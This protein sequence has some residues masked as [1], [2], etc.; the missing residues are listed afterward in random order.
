MSSADVWCPIYKW[1]QKRGT[2]Y[3]TIFVPCLC[4]DAV[5]VHITAGRLDFRAGRVASFAGEKTAAR[6]YHLPLELY[7]EVDADRSG[8]FLRHDHVR[9]ELRKV[10]QNLSWR[11]LQRA[12]VPKNKN[13]RPDFDHCDSDSEEE[14]GSSTSSSSTSRRDAPSPAKPAAAARR[15]GEFASKGGLLSYKAHLLSVSQTWRLDAWDALPMVVV[16]LL[17]I[18]CPYTKVEESFNLQATHDMLYHTTSLHKYDHLEF[19][20]ETLK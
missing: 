3:V 9:V 11:S 4:E 17:A 14:G 1:G 10:Q 18:V 5:T 8:Y 15:G 2:V 12:D 6:R 19:P 7:G 20:G 16:G 13:E